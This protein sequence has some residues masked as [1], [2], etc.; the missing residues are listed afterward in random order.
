MQI[1][2][3]SRARYQHYHTHYSIMQTC[4]QALKSSE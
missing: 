2:S 3:I 4:R 1:H